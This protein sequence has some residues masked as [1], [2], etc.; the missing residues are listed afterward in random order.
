M[1]ICPNSRLL[2]VDDNRI[3]LKVAQG[4]LAKYKANVDE[5]FSGQESI[6]K[7]KDNKYD[8]I[9]M[10]HMM[11]VMDGLEA[12]RKIRQQCGENGQVPIIALT[13]NVMKESEEMFLENGFDAFL[14]KPIDKV[15]L[16]QILDAYVKEEDKIPVEDVEENTLVSKEDLEKLSMKGVD[17]IC[18]LNLRKQGVDGYLELLELF[19]TDG[20]EKVMLIRNLAEVGDYT[21][22]EI[23]VHG[24]KSAAANIGAMELSG[25]AKEHEMAAKD[26]NY[27]LIKDDYDTLLK[28][29]DFILSEI[30]GVLTTYG[31]LGDA[32]DKEEN[33]SAIDDKELVKQVEKIL[34]LLEDFKPK[35]AAKSL[36]ELLKFHIA[37]ETKNVLHAIRAKLKLYDDD[38][39]EDMLRELLEV[40]YL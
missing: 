9:F 38:A 16:F 27:L 36:D 37:S 26:G 29:Y 4:L 33:L 12:T 34:E 17:V 3:N 11:P 21:N 22:Y 39:A 2:L 10:D 18:G 23:Q 15:E 5:A 1:F 14:A 40:L 30:E 7:V 32:G 25:K 20:L 13:A 24:L 19:Y 31:K 6:E 35:D 8:I 28:M